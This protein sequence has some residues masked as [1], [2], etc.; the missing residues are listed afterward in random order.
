MKRHNLLAV[1]IFSVALGGSLLLVGFGESDADV[2][3]GYQ[4]YLDFDAADDF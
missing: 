3:A 4:P 1:L 2:L